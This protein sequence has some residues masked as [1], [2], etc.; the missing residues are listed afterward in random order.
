MFHEGNDPE[1]H[2]RTAAV[3][4]YENFAMAEK[5][6]QYGYAAAASVILFIITAILGS[7]TFYMN[8]D[9]DEIRR[10]KRNKEAKKALKA[11]MAAAKEAF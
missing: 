6:R 5:K 10:K 3:F 11:Q 8:R 4:V 9:K 2:L 7:F 1:N